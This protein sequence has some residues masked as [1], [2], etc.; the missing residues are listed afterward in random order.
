[1]SLVALATWTLCQAAVF[2]A[3]AQRVMPGNPELTILE[4][5]EILRSRDINSRQRLVAYA[6]VSASGDRIAIQLEEQGRSP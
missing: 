6:H 2:I 3:S 1:M 4:A 5:L